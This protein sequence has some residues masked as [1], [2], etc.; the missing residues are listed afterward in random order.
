[1]ICC[2]TDEKNTLLHLL[3]VDFA[4]FPG[5]DKNGDDDVNDR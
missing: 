4:F 3:Q 1:M 2:F 5:E